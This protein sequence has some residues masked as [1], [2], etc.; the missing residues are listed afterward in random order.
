MIECHPFFIWNAIRKWKTYAIFFQK[1]SQIS[2]IVF[3]AN[4]LKVGNRLDQR[5]SRVAELTKARLSKRLVV[6]SNP[7]WHAYK[8]VGPSS[9]SRDMR[10]TDSCTPQSL[11]L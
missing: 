6:G 4:I 1:S 3:M 9:S 5:A 8:R 10:F 2:F 11:A 7:L